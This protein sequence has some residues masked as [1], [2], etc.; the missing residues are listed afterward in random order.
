[1]SAKA[2]SHDFELFG[3]SFTLQRW[4][5]F[6]AEDGCAHVAPCDPN[7]DLE[8]PHELTWQCPCKPKYEDGVCAHELF[9]VEH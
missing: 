7:N 8:E 9:S 4:G 5:I 1:M 3:C 2:D 6:L